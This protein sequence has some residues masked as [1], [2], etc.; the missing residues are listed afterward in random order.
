VTPA[1]GSGLSTQMSGQGTTGIQAALDALGGTLDRVVV[2]QTLVGTRLA[3]VALLNDRLQTDS[4]G[5]TTEISHIEDL[6]IAKAAT[7]LQQ[8]QTTYEGSLASAAR[9]AQVSLLDFLR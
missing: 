3:W 6:D 4:L 5:V 2:P 1:A 8:L 9:L 7:F